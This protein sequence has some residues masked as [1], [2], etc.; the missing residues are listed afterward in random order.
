M[1]VGAGR[2]EC[3]RHVKPYVMCAPF[4]PTYNE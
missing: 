1:S 4:V 2:H 3:L